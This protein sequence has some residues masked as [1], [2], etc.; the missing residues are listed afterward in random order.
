MIWTWTL[1]P[2][3]DVTAYVLFV[4]AIIIVGW[5]LDPWGNE[6]PFY[7]AIAPAALHETMSTQYPDDLP[8]PL[9]GE[10]LFVEIEARDAAGNLSGP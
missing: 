8:A 3:P 9:E 10:V 6:F 4:G 5:G 7:M 1:S 2:S